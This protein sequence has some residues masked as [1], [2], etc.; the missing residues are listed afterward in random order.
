MLLASLKNDLFTPEKDS[1]QA[2]A[3]RQEKWLSAVQNAMSAQYEEITPFNFDARICVKLNDIAW[4]QN[5]LREIEVLIDSE[6]KHA[7]LE[8]HRAKKILKR[9]TKNELFWFTIRI[10]RAKD[11]LSRDTNGLSDPYVVVSRNDKYI[12]KTKTIFEN[13][14]PVWDETIEIEQNEAAGVAIIQTQIWDENSFTKHS[15]CGQ[16]QFVLDPKEYQDFVPVE[17]WLAISPK[18]SILV[19]VTMESEKDDICYYFEKCM[20][21]AV[22]SEDE[23]IG[24]IVSKFSSL[25]S[26]YVSKSTVNN[27][28]GVGGYKSIFSGMLKK[29]QKSKSSQDSTLDEDKIANSLD[30]LF[31]YLNANFAAL[32]QN[33]TKSLRDKVMIQTWNALLEALELILM[34]PLSDKK[35]TQ[36]PLSENELTIVRIWSD[37]MLLFFHNDGYGIPLDKL[38]SIKYNSF[39]IALSYYYSADTQDL[40]KECT[41]RALDSIIQLIESE[42]VTVSGKVN[43]TEKDLDLNNPKSISADP[44]SIDVKKLKRASSSVEQSKELEILLLRMLRMRGENEFVKRLL[45]QKTNLAVSQSSS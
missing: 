29:G 37:V 7:V 33:L 18:G 42:E 41:D 32:S 22:L 6:N 35:T 2:F 15:L 4:A 20:R 19:S 21:R 16:A 12:G 36:A 27:I 24:M 25:I 40:I 1:K 3:S 30:P 9:G 28:L 11:L 43:G 10:I 13:L 31:E 14:D 39:F 34:P 38:K 26:F 44:K 17:K 45:N 23:I 8:Q 5:K